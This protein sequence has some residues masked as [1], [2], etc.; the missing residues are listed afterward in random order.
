MSNSK[1][2]PLIFDNVNPD[3]G[4]KLTA[5]EGGYDQFL[6]KL[7]VWFDLQYFS[8]TNNSACHKW[9]G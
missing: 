3:S 9:Q 5:P 1:I 8:S 6:F 2:I 4:K 7:F